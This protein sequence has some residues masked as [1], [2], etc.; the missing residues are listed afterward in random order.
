MTGGAGLLGS[1]ISTALAELG[2]N[3]VIG[4]RD[5]AKCKQF[6]DELAAQ[7]PEQTFSGI[8][9]DITSMDSAKAAVAHTVELN[10]GLDILVNCSW[11][12]RKNSFES[13][14]EED[15]MFDIDI[16]LH[17]VFRTI[18]AAV[19]ALRERKGVILNI[20]SMYGIVAPDYR[21]YEGTNHVNPPSYGAG[22]AAV[23]QFTRYLASFLSPDG[24]RVN[25]ISPGPFPYE[26]TQEQ[27]PD[28]IARLG[29]KNPQG[30]I[31]KPHELKG[32]AALLCS[33]ASSYMTGQ[34]ISVDGGWTAW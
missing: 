6:A 2:A 12:G 25:A 27:F 18:K 5:E 31:G 8:G 26:S 3:V 10:G 4:S 11:T 34:N 22:K 1:Q 29:A 23:L 30:R 7:F 21:I 20:A 14:T 33:D 28:F 17:G 16:C 24:I 19:P 13:I 32:A 15:W 9:L